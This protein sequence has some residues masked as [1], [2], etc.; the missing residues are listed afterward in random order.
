LPSTIQ[1]VYVRNRIDIDHVHSSAISQE[2]GE[3]LQAFLINQPGPAP[4]LGK[5]IE[6]LGE[7]KQHPPSMRPPTGRA[8]NEPCGDRRAGVDRSKAWLRLA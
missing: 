1:E 8:S 3:R 5:K 4:G 2:I 7:P 6:Q